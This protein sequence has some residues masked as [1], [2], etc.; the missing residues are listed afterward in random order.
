MSEENKIGNALKEYFNKK[1]ITQIQ[2]AERLQ[3]TQ[4]I[5]SRLLNGKP[6]GKSTAKKWSKEFDFNPTFLLTG[7]GDLLFGKKEEQLSMTK[8]IIDTGVSVF[9]EQVL[10]LITSGE[11]YP[12]HIVREQ[13]AEIKRLNREIGAL[14][15]QI[16]QLKEKTFNAHAG[17]A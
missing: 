3:S 17:G 12:A 13:D 9:S 11:L 10:T 8:K 15:K 1:E 4:P 6:F 2:I 7:D 14:Q 5:V 16:E